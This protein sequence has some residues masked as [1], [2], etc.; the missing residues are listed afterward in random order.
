MAEALVTNPNWQ[1]FATNLEL[2]R[3][4]P[5]GLLRA[6]AMNETR[7]GHPDWINAQSSAKAKGMFQFM[8]GTARQY[9][10]N[11][12]DPAD[13]TRGAADFLADLNKKYSDPHLAAAAYNWGPGNLDKAVAKAKA[14]GMSTDAMS[15]ANNGFLP[16][17]TADYVRK[18]PSFQVQSSTPTPSE[19]A[20]ASSAYSPEVVQSTRANVLK[21][22]EQGIADKN[23]VDSLKNSAVKDMISALRSQG[24]ADSDIV[25]QIAGKDLE[26]VR[27][28]QNESG[29][30]GVIKGGSAGLEDLGRGA[31][32][33][34]ATGDREQQLMDEQKAAEADPERRMRLDTTSG[35]FG[36]YGAQVAP[37]IAADMMAPQVGGPLTL[38]RMAALGG[39]QGALTPTTEPGKR[40]GNVVEGAAVGGGIGAAAA[41]P[42]ALVRSGQA[43]LRG[44]EDVATINARVA[45]R[46]AAG[47]PSSASE[48]SHR[49]GRVADE[50]GENVLGA[51]WFG[52][53]KR[54]LREPEIAQAITSR[55]GAP[56]NELSAGVVRQAQKNIS[57]L[58][59][60]ALD[61]VKIELQ[62]SFVSAID[63]IAASHEAGT[64]SS[65]ASRVPASVVE[66]LKGLAAQGTVDAHRIQA[67]RSSLGQAMTATENATAK[68][69]LG[70]I[71]EE[72]NTA[73]E[74][75]LRDAQGWNLP[76]D[77]LTKF[78]K[79]NEQ[80]RSLQVVEN[81]GRRTNWSGEDFNAKKFMNSIKAENVSSFVR[82]E[83]PFQDLVA[84]LAV[85]KSGSALG[86]FGPLGNAIVAG[87]MGSLKTPVKFAVAG[88]L[89][90][91]I[92]TDPK[93][94]DILLGLNPVQKSQLMK[95]ASAAQ[96]GAVPAIKSAVDQ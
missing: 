10:V 63:D 94:R 26:V 25:S 86:G 91:R 27:R 5:S 69:A 20:P 41:L 48:V 43:A 38:A 15:L 47:I 46:A 64:V 17:E 54:L 80:Y 58:Y 78:Q 83:A 89:A 55:I 84:A 95:V 67:I 23:I 3:G 9:N 34:F 72:L 61:G 18:L 57:K 22:A 82:G 4:L 24:T 50:V 12:A 49:A 70:Q 75:G 40:T 60:D 14:Q 93:Y 53:D 13:S 65:L 37:L 90:L 39:A 11:V 68:K 56:S 62:P 7:G 8:D 88:Q 87:N 96:V 32:Q 44:G 42:N 52:A 85:S 81:Y 28:V 6:I 35:K 1:S 30:Q 29:L 51:K 79:A 2:D 66:D 16:K 73:L 21:M 71:R 19:A 45:E 36:Y 77:R 92:L 76:A 59:D 31:K 33:I 74:T